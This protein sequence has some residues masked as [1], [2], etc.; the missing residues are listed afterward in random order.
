MQSRSTHI[1]RR[2]REP[3]TKEAKTTQP[4][5]SC[6]PTQAYQLVNTRSTRYGREP[7]NAKPRIPPRDQELIEPKTPNSHYCLCFYD[8][9]GNYVKVLKCIMVPAEYCGRKANSQTHC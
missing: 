1:L 7:S 9:V 2:S 3:T 4:P 5:T 6:E 8:F